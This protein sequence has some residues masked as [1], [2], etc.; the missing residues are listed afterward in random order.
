MPMPK[1][2][3]QLQERI[4]KNEH[5][6]N[7]FSLYLAFKEPERECLDQEKKIN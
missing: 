2:Y 3:Q 5:E 6:E 7:S 4:V 1:T